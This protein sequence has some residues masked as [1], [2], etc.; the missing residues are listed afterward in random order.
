LVDKLP[1][2]VLKLWRE[3]RSK[4]TDSS[5]PLSPTEMEQMLQEAFQQFDDS[6]MRRLLDPTATV[7]SKRPA[8]SGSCLLMACIDG[9]DLFLANTGDC[10][11]VLITSKTNGQSSPPSQQ[12]LRAVELTQDQTLHNPSERARLIAE[13]PH[14]DPTVLT[15]R[16][17]ILGGL[18]PTRA[19][20]D[21]KYKASVEMHRQV[22]VPKN[23]L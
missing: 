8:L 19:F 5:T 11:A 20:G 14:D 4:K 6:L 9:P 23:G 10:R 22:G 16:N 7:E 21:A 13:H 3:R 18:E 15:A 12:K 1:D 17:R 2:Q